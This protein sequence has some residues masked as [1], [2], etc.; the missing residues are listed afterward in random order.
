ML[1]H[2]LAVDHRYHVPF[3]LIMFDVDYFKQINDKYGHHTGDEV[4]RHTAS[5]IQGR[6]RDTDIFARYGGEEFVIHLPHTMKSDA[7]RLAEELRELVESQV[8]STDRGDVRVTISMGVISMEGRMY[9]GSPKQWLFDLLREAD[10]AL[11]KAKRSGRNRI[12]SA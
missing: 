10:N 12:V 11:Y 1:E 2:Q 4:L 8:I 6:L 5:V 7:L 3:S 9:E